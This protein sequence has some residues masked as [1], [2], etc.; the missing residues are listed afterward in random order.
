MPRRRTVRYLQFVVA[1]FCAGVSP[2]W[3]ADYD[4]LNLPP[5]DPNFND[6]SN[7]VTGTVP[8]SGDMAVFN[9][10]DSEVWFQSNVSNQRLLVRNG[11]FD[12]DL[13]GYTYELTT[14]ADPLSQINVGYLNGDDATLSISDGELLSGFTSIGIE[15]GS[16]GTLNVGA[17]ATL[18][19]VLTVGQSGTGILN[20]SN[21]GRVQPKFAGGGVLQAGLNAG[22]AGYVTVDGVGSQIIADYDVWWGRGDGSHGEFAISNGAAFFGRVNEMA[23]GDNSTATGTL[24]SGGKYWS[25]FSFYMAAGDGSSA[26][27][28]ITGAGSTLSVGSRLGVGRLGTAVLNVSDGGTLVTHGEAQ[29][30]GHFAEATGEVNLDGDG[31]LW[32]A[33]NVVNIGGDD[34][35]SNEGVGTLNIRNNAVMD[36]EDGVYVGRED[37][38]QGFLTVT[39]GGRLNADLIYAGSEGATSG[40]ILVSDGGVIDVNGFFSVAAGSAHITGA[41]SRLQ[42][43]TTSVSAGGY[44]A[45]DNG[46]I[47]V[48]D[49]AV[50]DVRSAHSYNFMHIDGPGTLVEASYIVST[51]SI[52]EGEIRVTNGGRI[53]TAWLAGIQYTDVDVIGTGSRIDAERVDT[54]SRIGVY[55]GASVNA[56]SFFDVGFDYDLD[57][58]DFASEVNVV[59]AS[60]SAGTYVR[61]QDA[62]SLNLKGGIVSSQAVNIEEGAALNVSGIFAGAGLGGSLI[63]GDVTNDGSIAVTNNGEANFADAVVNNGSFHV[64][65]GSRSIFAGAVS[66]SGAF[67]GLGELYFLDSVGPGNSPGLLTVEGDVNFSG[68][69]TFIAELAG[70]TRGTEYDA[71][72]IGGIADLSGTLEVLFIDGFDAEVG[73]AFNL[74]TAG[75]IIGE[76]DIA[77]LPELARQDM[78]WA[79]DYILNAGGA[80][81]LRIRAVPIPGAV[82]LFVSALGFLGWRSKKTLH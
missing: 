27:L 54:R 39:S 59:G 43:D 55:N 6:T 71:F 41:G 25:N 13:N 48:D 61:L 34:I 24:S 50:V 56:A 79:T 37:F 75:T 29:L 3:S 60:I 14:R 45:N 47:L 17:G 72:D 73:D 77:L 32:N 44:G 8:G 18:T 63:S 38:N 64:E 16:T 11:E 35:F 2:A 26:T 65:G 28:D 70:L 36:A 74:L 30:G 58:H 68:S 12:F 5:T 69:S 15:A 80:D 10:A 66:G 82:W 42:G 33:K 4:W 20:V 46:E 62:V 49:G 53:E 51:E 7:W 52:G 23:S 22:S 78:F 81:R 31:T 40:E 67:T 1:C 21:G 9:G 19:S 76:F 57:G